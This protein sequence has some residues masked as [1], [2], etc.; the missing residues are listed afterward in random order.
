M[1]RRFIVPVDLFSWDVPFKDYKPVSFTHSS[2]LDANS[3]PSDLD[4]NILPFNRWDEKRKRNRITFDKSAPFRVT[5][6]RPLNP[7]G[8]TGISGR[9]VLPSWGTNHAGLYRVKLSFL[10][11]F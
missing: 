6:G 4:V 3:D 9:G 1:V 11:S 7:I 5:D 2:V 10:T 8:R